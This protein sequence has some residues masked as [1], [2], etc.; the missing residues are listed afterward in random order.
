MFDY[1]TRTL[2]L[3]PNRLHAKPAPLS[4]QIYRQ[5]YTTILIRIQTGAVFPFNRDARTI[6]LLHTMWLN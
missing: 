6:D 1:H 4:T 2:V 3:S 5:H